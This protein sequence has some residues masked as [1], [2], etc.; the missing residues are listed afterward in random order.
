M[1]ARALGHPGGATRGGGKA[2]ED[3]Y[4]VECAAPLF[5]SIEPGSSWPETYSMESMPSL[6][7]LSGLPFMSMSFDSDDGAAAAHTAY[8][9][10]HVAP[11]PSVGYSDVAPLGSQPGSYESLSSGEHLLAASSRMLPPQL[12]SCYPPVGPLE[13]R[14]QPTA[15]AASAP[16]VASA[17]ASAFLTYCQVRP[18]QYPQITTHTLVPTGQQIYERMRAIR[19][20][21]EQQAQFSAETKQL[22]GGSQAATKQLEM[23]LDLVLRDYSTRLN[24]YLRGYSEAVAQQQLLLMERTALIGAGPDGNRCRSRIAVAEA[25]MEAKLSTLSQECLKTI[26]GALEGYRRDSTQ[27]LTKYM[28]QQKKKEKLPDS[29]VATLNTWLQENFANPYPTKSQKLALVEA[30]GLEMKQINQWFINARVRVWRPAVQ[31]MMDE[32]TDS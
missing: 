4:I 26:D 1:D 21:I 15:T 30:T 2:F 12:P 16:E 23:Q 5:C 28:E 6:G 17:S 29:A 18:P 19:R 7:S 22:R 14:P 32:Q 31:M 8:A 10:H 25:H 20:G 13:V 9:P 3:A 24:E 27:L 11:Q